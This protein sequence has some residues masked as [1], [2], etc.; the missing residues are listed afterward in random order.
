MDLFNFL[1]N[2]DVIH[3]ME[4][5]EIFEFLTNQRT[6]ATTYATARIVI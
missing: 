3:A 4:D 2:G 6:K 5:I 1:P